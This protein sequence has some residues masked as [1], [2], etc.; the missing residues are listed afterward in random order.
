MTLALFDF[1]ASGAIAG[2][3]PAPRMWP[4]GIHEL[5][6]GDYDHVADCWEYVCPDCGGGL[7]RRTTRENDVMRFTAV[8][9]SPSGYR[10]GYCYFQRHSWERVAECLA[11]HSWWFSGVGCHNRACRLFVSD[12]NWGAQH[13]WHRWFYSQPDDREEGR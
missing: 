13:D 8:H 12:E 10:S 7:D 9:G 1:D 5:Y 3:P 11:C 6:R 2:P 4:C